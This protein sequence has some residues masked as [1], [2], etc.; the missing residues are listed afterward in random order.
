MALGGAESAEVLR[1]RTRLAQGLGS[2]VSWP[3]RRNMTETTV[4][5]IERLR[6]K[7]AESGTDLTVLG[8]T[9]HLLWLAGLDPHGDE[10]PV[11]LLVSQAYAGLLMPDLNAAS[12]RQH[13]DL[14]FHTWKDHEGPDAALRDLISCCGVNPADLSVALD[15]AMRTDFAFRVLAALPGARTSFTAATVSALRAEKGEEEYQALKA[16]AL[17]NDRAVMA[18]FDALR[19]GISELEVAEAIA[20]FYA[21][22]G[23][24]TEFISVCFGSNGAFCHHHTGPSRLKRD[25]AVMIDAGGRLNGY[26][27][28]MTRM[29]WFGTPTPEF[30]RVAGVVEGAVQAALAAARPGVPAQRVD[31]A[32]REVITAA[33]HGPDFLHRTGHGLGIELHEEPYVT[34]AS[35]RALATGNVFSIEPGIYLVGQFGVRLEEIVYLRPDGPEILSEL[36]RTLVIRG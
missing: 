3:E 25:M 26:P 15:E 34:G 36:P 27:S 31:R 32:A 14:P 6:R 13:T 1:N 24:T 23:A 9:S 8:P 10:R 7:M 12:V 22:N 30:L 19:E 33:G 2:L 35:E 28:D 5:K 11:L 17:L 20:A 18:G 4:A 29:G 21:A 16:S